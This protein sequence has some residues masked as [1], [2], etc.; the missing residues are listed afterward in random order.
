[1]SCNKHMIHQP[2]YGNPVR[3]SRS[4][5]SC[6]P[7]QKLRK[8]GTPKRSGLQ[9]GDR[10]MGRALSLKLQ[11]VDEYRLRQRQKAD[12][13]CCAPL[14]ETAKKFNVHKSLV[15]KWAAKE[16]ELKMSYDARSRRQVHH[17]LRSIQVANAASHWPRRIHSQCVRS[18]ALRVFV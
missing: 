6:M 2:R 16:D 8:D 10:R 14:D 5:L 1:M 18:I 11:V 15:S 7:A 3:C 9:E 17:A 12:G 4:K 13:Q